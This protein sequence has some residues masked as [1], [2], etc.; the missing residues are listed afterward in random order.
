MSIQQRSEETYH[1]I[2]EAAGRS[3][4]QQGYDA[5]GVAEIC[6]KAGV[7]KG[8]FYYHFS[9]KQALFLELLDRWLDEID[10]ELTAL[11]AEAET[12]PEALLAMAH[13]LQQVFRDATGR[14]PILLEFWRKAQRD[15]EIWEATIEPYRRYQERF[16][17]LIST[18]VAEGSLRPVDSRLAARTLVS[19]AVGLVLQG[20]LNPEGADWG[21]EATESVRLLLDGLRAGEPPAAP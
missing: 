3:F 21:S 2:L 16:A 9:S 13:A 6:R 11:G 5:T 12:V 7:S 19:L 18:G 20:T 1:R 14:L 17:A 10:E 15:P 8:A 4:A